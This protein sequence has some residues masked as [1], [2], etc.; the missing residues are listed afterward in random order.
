MKIKITMEIEYEIDGEYNPEMEQ[1]VCELA[2]DSISSDALV[3]HE[4]ECVLFPCGKEI[5]KIEVEGMEH[6]NQ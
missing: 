1:L 3:L 5:I 4:D 2:G 6:A